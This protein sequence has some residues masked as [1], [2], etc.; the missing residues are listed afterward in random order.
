MNLLIVDD[1]PIAVRGM[2]EGIDRKACGLTHIWTAYSG[3]NALQILN[4]QQVDLMLCDIEMPGLNGIELLRAV[5]RV[6]KDIV[7]IF[8]TCQAKFEY[9]QEA[10][11]LGCREYLLK[12]VPYDV[13]T[14]KIRA[15]VK[16]LEIQNH[17]QELER[18]RPEAPDAAASRENRS[19]EEIVAEVEAYILENLSDSA[20][21][22]SDIAEKMF[23]NKDYL[24]RVFKKQKGLSISQFLIGERMKLAG[25]LLADPKNS[26][27]YAAERTGYDN[28]PY[29]ASS[30]KRYYGCSPTQYQKDRKK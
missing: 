28:Y 26:V 12:P 2:M 15:A 19:Q 16:E 21:L 11:A 27:N 20:L 9:A 23:L 1:E 7:C 4:A 3:E 17:R 29:F 13:L 30:F 5:R 18:Y 8:L 25:L 14:E 10:V 24:N 22:V 6:N